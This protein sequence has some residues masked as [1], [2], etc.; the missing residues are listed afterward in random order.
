MRLTETQVE[1]LKFVAVGASTLAIDAGT[2]AV[3]LYA[4]PGLRESVGRA[5]GPALG[6]GTFQAAFI[7]LRV[8][9]TILSILNSYYWNRRW[10]FR[11]APS[12]TQFVR[13]W[14]VS[15]SAMLVNQA[16]AATIQ[17]LFHASSGLG[18]ATTHLCAAFVA[19]LFNFTGQRRWTF[20]KDA[21]EEVPLAEGDYPRPSGSP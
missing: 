5:F 6:L 16:T 20:R 7:V 19:T 8:P 18:F 21:L 13:F 3:L 15:L 12:R 9:G 11:V 1:F 17:I 10:T 4:V 2:Q 14:V